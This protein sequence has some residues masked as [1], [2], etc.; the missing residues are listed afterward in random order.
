MVQQQQ[1][2]ELPVCEESENPGYFYASSW[3][4]RPVLP[5]REESAVVDAGGKL[6]TQD[7]QHE[8][9]A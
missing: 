2:D 9:E 1:V 7:H 4:L 6:G 8:A 3:D 5:A